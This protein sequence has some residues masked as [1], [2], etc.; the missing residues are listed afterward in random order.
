[1]TYNLSKTRSVTKAN[2]YKYCKL[3][4]KIIWYG[5]KKI[6]ILEIKLVKIKYQYIKVT[7]LS[8]LNKLFKRTICNDCTKMNE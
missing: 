1:M 2:Y 8:N 6:N 3:K 4:K 7:K 5:N